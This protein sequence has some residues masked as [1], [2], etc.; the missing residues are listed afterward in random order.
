MSVLEGA[1]LLFRPQSSF[2]V[3]RFI[4]RTIHL[5]DLQSLPLLLEDKGWAGE[6]LRVRNCSLA[7]A[8]GGV[9]DEQGRDTDMPGEGEGRKETSTEGVPSLRVAGTPA[10]GEQTWGLREP[11]PPLL[12][13]DLAESL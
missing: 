11:A 5:P 1:A 12:L 2:A 7:R 4:P 8:W 3:R 9:G 10:A 13:H 6:E